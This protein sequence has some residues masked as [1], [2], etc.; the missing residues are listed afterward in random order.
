[1]NTPARMSAGRLGQ[2]TGKGLPKH[3]PKM[4]LD[5]AMPIGCHAFPDSTPWFRSKGRDEGQLNNVFWFESMR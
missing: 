1:M 3:S 4:A 5:K 2:A